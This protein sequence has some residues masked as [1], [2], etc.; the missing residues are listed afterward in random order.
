MVKLKNKMAQK[1]AMAKLK[2][3]VAKKICY[4]QTE[5]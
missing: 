5:K 1:S 4:G 3:N 2:N